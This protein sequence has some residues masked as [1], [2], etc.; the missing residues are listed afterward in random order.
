ML[1]KPRRST[2]WP[3]TRSWASIPPQIKYVILSHSHAE[4]YGGGKYFQDTYHS[5]IIMGGPDWDIIEKTPNPPP[6]KRDISITETYKLTLGNT[7]VMI[8]LAPGH[9]P[10]TLNLLVPVTDH[11]QPHMLSF[12]GGTGIPQGMDSLLQY[13]DSL[14]RFTKIGE[15]AN[16]DGVISSHPWFG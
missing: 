12:V 16:V 7:T 5:H 11:G 8:Y 2:L 13:R 4:H 1:T 9:T 3:A 15:D 14:S 10:G 6:A